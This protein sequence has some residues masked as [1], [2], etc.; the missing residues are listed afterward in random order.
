MTRAPT[1]PIHRNRRNSISIRFS[2]RSIRFSRCGLR[3]CRPSPS[4]LARARRQGDTLPPSRGRVKGELA[5]HRDSTTGGGRRGA[6]PCAGRGRR[7]RA[8]GNGRG[9][10]GLPG[11]AP[12]RWAPCG[13]GRGQRPRRGA[14]ERAE[15]ARGATIRDGQ[16][17][18]CAIQI[19]E[20][21]G[22]SAFPLA[23]RQENQKLH[24]HSVG[25]LD[26]V[27]HANE[28]TQCSYNKR[29]R[30]PVRRQ[31][32]FRQGSLFKRL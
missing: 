26:R 21:I 31:P 7:A 6:G 1:Y 22:G 29:R 5:L 12:A 25:R 32:P 17:Q 9:R 15:A 16:T 30:L 14:R 11:C 4:R 19:V 23:R 18:R 20:R 2:V 10:T 24:I 27:P 13:T 28:S 3:A 8:K